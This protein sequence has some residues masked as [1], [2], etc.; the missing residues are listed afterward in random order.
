LL[1]ARFGSAPRASSRAA[2]SAWPKKLARP[3]AVKPSVAKA[4]SS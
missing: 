2:A 4:S 3:R 1:E